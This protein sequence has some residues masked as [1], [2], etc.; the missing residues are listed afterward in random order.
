[1]HSVHKPDGAVHSV[2]KTDGAVHK[3]DGAHP[4]EGVD[5]LKALVDWLREKAGE[6]LVVENFQVAT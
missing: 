3:P 2:H 5:G 6:L 1:M 4:G